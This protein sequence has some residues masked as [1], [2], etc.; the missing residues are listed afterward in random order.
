MNLSNELKDTLMKIITIGQ[1]VIV[2]KQD[3]KKRKD[4][5]MSLTN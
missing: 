3:F 4:L 2:S 1:I 5:N